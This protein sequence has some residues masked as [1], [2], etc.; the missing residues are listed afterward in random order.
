MGVWYVYNVLTFTVCLSVHCT[1]GE[2][3]HSPLLCV[4]LYTVLQGNVLTFTVCLSVHCT[5]GE[6]AHFY[7]VFICTLY[8]RGMCSLL[9]CVYLY[10]VLQGNV[11]TFTVCLSV[12]CTAG[13]C[14][15][16]E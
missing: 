2:C 8:C 10:T 3:A 14:D 6:C 13:E 9:L 7:C 12:H 16:S 11:L 5:A 1:A 15:W 4:Y